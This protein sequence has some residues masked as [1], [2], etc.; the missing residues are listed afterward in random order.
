[1]TTKLNKEEIHKLEKLGYDLILRKE[2]DLIYSEDLKDIDT[3]FCFRAFDHLDISLLPKLKWIQLLSVGINHVPKDKIINQN[4]ILT[5]NKSGYSIPI[6][7]WIVLKLLEMVKNSKEFYEK[8]KDRI[9]K[10]DNSLLEL[11]DKT[12]GFIG[13]GSIAGET[14]KRLQG[15]GMNV[16]GFNSSG[17]DVEYF[18][19]TYSVDKMKDTIGQCDFVVV[20]VPYTDKTHHLLDERVFSHM[21]DGTYLVNIARG[22]IIDEQALIHN[23]RNG[24]IK[25]A[26]LDVFEVEPLPETSPLWDMDNV[27][28]SSHTSGRSDQNHKRL[29]NMYYENMKRFIHNEELLNVVDFKKGY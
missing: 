5:N 29:F 27:I 19:K 24:K 9:W 28:L 20:T 21:K 1:M 7:E 10:A 17:R 26:A 14:A 12:V 2:E 11:Y 16:V 22:S 8:Q 4:I 6:A 15:F 13:T 3:M 25:K 18:H 23:L